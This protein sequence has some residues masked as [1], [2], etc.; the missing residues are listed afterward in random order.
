MSFPVGGSGIGIKAERSDA[1]YVVT[2]LKRKGVAEQDGTLKVG[3]LLVTVDGVDVASSL[4]AL[5]SLVLGPV[6]T[7]ITIGFR[8]DPGGPLYHVT[9]IRGGASDD[10]APHLARR[11]LVSEEDTEYFQ[12]SHGRPHT[13]Q[14]ISTS[15]G[16]H[17][18]DQ[19]AV[20]GLD[21][22]PE[23]LDH[24]RSMTVTPARQFS[25]SFRAKENAADMSDESL[26]A[27]RARCVAL[28]PGTGPIPY[29]PT[30]AAYQLDLTD[31]NGR[32]A[33][34][35]DKAPTAGYRIVKSKEA[36]TKVFIDEK[37][38]PQDKKSDHEQALAIILRT[39][40]GKIW[41]AE[42]KRAK[43]RLAL[44]QKHDWATNSNLQG[45]TGGRF[46]HSKPKSEIDWMV[47][48]TKDIPA[49]GTYNPPPK[50]SSKTTKFGTSQR[51]LSIL[52]PG[53]EHVPGVGEYDFKMVK[54]VA[55]ATGGRFSNS[56]RKGF[57]DGVQREASRLP[58]PGEYDV[59]EALPVGPEGFFFGGKGQ[60]GAE[61]GAKAARRVPGPGMYDVLD[62]KELGKK[63]VVKF[64]IKAGGSFV[65][66]EVKRVRDHP[67]PQD[68]RVKLEEQQPGGRFSRSSVP[69]NTEVLCKESAKIPGPGRYKIRGFRARDSGPS[70]KGSGKFSQAANVTLIDQIA[71]R[72]RNYPAPG[73]YYQERSSTP[74]GV[75]A[76]HNS[77]AKSDLEWK[78]YH[79]KQLPGPGE[80]GAPMKPITQA[81]AG[82]ISSSA[83]Q[84]DVDVRLRETSRMPGPGQYEVKGL[85]QGGGVVRLDHLPRSEAEWRQYEAHY[86][87]MRFRGNSP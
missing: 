21:E 11:S 25:E 28:I 23:A 26:R 52:P 42:R 50:R 6:G 12:S 70:V 85:W 32:T 64:G 34:A 22:D 13:S 67:G 56:D 38:A 7:A 2:H 46:N 16:E 59:P 63:G 66:E 27:M 8:R 61:D 84:S 58:G 51:A 82:K 1:G 76:I 60:R 75:V 65:D 44:E 20:W 68:Y 87:E 74:K 18:P 45:V 24:R 72:S 49:V 9:L 35:K 43:E 19:S 15:D 53:H 30:G 81:N 39:P 14:G 33:H 5:P 10:D 80:Y 55:A 79:A 47:H 36:D 29:L 31:V 41:Q 69:S 48:A 83:R 78:L 71:E 77:N 17:S 37:S 73:H 86:P 4:S 40:E 3:D 57:L 54:S 62:K